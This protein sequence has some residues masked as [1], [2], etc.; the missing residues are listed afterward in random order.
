[1]LRDSVPSSQP[2]KSSDL[3]AEQ[4]M[5]VKLILAFVDSHVPGF[6]GYYRALNESDKENRISDLLVHHFELCKD[7]SGGFFPFRFSKNPT[8]KESTKETD[9]GIFVRTRD[10]KPVPIFEFE[11][12]R[13]SETS[14]N[15]EYVS[16]IRGGIERFK[17]SD[18]SSLLKVC[19]MFGYVQSRTSAEWISN[20]NNWIDN[21]SKNNTDKTIDWTNDEE[22]LTTI[23]SLTSVEKLYSLNKRESSKDKIALWH[24]FIDLISK[25]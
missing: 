25:N 9:I 12:K 17:R 4:D 16:G 3:S 21:L 22:K 19:G 6:S 14:N 5:E 15:K 8:Q 2:P 1:M 20:V 11:A 18:H 24:Y 10:R 13:F 7:E 23:A